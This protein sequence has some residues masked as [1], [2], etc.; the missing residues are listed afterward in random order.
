MSR[1]ITLNI[2]GGSTKQYSTLVL[3]LN[4]MAKSWS[5][6]GVTISLPDQERIINWGNRKHNDG[7][8]PAEIHN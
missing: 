8:I 5:K 6:Y 2:K 3:E 4:N 7:D 1:K